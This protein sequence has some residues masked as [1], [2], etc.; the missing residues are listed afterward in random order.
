[1]KQKTETKAQKE[2]RRK[3]HRELGLEWTEDA[4]QLELL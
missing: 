4:V 3:L 2:I 1:M